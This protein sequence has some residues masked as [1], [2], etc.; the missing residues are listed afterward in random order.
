MIKL[1]VIAWS[2]LLILFFQYHSIPTS[3]SHYPTLPIYLLYLCYYNFLP[4]PTF[5]FL[6]SIH[7]FYQYPHFPPSFFH[8]RSYFSS[9][10]LHWCFSSSSPLF[11]CLS[12]FFFYCV[13]YTYPYTFFVTSSLCCFVKRNSPYCIHPYLVSIH[14]RCT[15]FRSPRGRL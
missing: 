15:S 14:Q 12:S 7:L 6:L 4:L 5:L 2:I 10:F 3:F 8:L 13:F 1:T 9:S 11:C